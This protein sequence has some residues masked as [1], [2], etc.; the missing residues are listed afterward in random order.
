MYHI[1][2]VNANRGTNAGR[3]WRLGVADGFMRAEGRNAG[4]MG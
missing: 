4:G 1:S 3:S 2:Q